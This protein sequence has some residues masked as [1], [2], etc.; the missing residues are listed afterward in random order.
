MILVKQAGKK[1][2]AGQLVIIFLAWKAL[3]LVLA[4]ICP[5][6]GYDTSA[7]I[8]LDPSTNRHQNVVSRWPQDRL[9]LNLFR[10]DSIYFIAAAKRN[11]VHEQEWAFSWAYSWLLRLA[12]HCERVHYCDCDQD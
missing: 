11:K 9:V 10:W 12:G 1:G 7:L 5:S 6:P 2:R 8:L 3:L 4:T